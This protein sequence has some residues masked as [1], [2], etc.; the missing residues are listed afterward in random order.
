MLNISEQI[1]EAAGL[2][3]FGREPDFVLPRPPT[4][5]TIAKLGDVLDRAEHAADH[6]WDGD[7]GTY[8]GSPDTMPIERYYAIC[9]R[10]HQAEIEYSRAVNAR[11]H[12]AQVR[13]EQSK[14]TP[15]HERVAELFTAMAHANYH[16]DIIER[17]RPDFAS[18]REAIDAKAKAI[19]AEHLYEIA[20]SKYRSAAR[21]ARRQGKPF[22]DR[23]RSR[24]VQFDSDGRAYYRTGRYT[25]LDG[26]RIPIVEYIQ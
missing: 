11:D 10:R 15:S 8:W 25:S 5:R 20:L 12:F 22:R 13:A 2:T 1:F 17:C 23:P 4:P 21:A 19:H 14:R 18:V 7:G 3:P 24:P 16:L 9:D 26:A 6:V